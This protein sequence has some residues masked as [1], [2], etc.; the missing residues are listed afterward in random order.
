MKTHLERL[1]SRTRRHDCAKL[2]T[3]KQ[4]GGGG[5]RRAAIRGKRPWQAGRNRQSITRGIVAAISK[6]W[7]V[8]EEICKRSKGWEKRGRMRGMSQGLEVQVRKWRKR[9]DREEKEGPSSPEGL[10]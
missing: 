1:S 2:C 8:S 7:K 5:R 3:Q 4:K 10:I 9:E 6:D